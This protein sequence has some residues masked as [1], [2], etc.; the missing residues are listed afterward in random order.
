MA[1][2]TRTVSARGGGRTVTREEMSASEASAAAGQAE[3]QSVVAEAQKVDMPV[4]DIPPRDLV[5]LP[6]GL[7]HK[8]RLYQTAEVKELNGHDE[9]VLARA[10]QAQV[11]NPYYFMD[12]ILKCGVTQIGDASPADTEK[13]LGELLI[14]DREMLILEIRRATYGD[15]LELPGWQ[16]PSCSNSADLEMQLD[17]IPI[18]KVTDIQDELE[19]D[20]KL[21]KGATAHV[22]LANGNDLLA[23]YEKQ[24]LTTAQRETIL[25]SRC[26]DYITDASGF[27]SYMAARP[28]MAL[29]MSM[30]DRHAILKE[31]DE[32]Q[33]GPKYNK[34]DFTCETCGKE[35]QLRVELNHLFL[36]LRWF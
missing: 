1:T 18:S 29:E 4:I 35:T 28:S 32:R 23:I 9:E 6:G 15:N 12:K 13:L 8:N 24:E 36:D 14:G 19:F 3:I 30:P 21:K 17:D 16:C 20:V 34:I 27:E 7:F 5:Q 33:P 11:F 25:L 22:K 2:T 10:S 31:L 26:V